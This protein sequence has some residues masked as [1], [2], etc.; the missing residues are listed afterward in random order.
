[1]EGKRGTEGLI[2]IPG[3]D[4]NANTHASKLRR[5]LQPVD[6][7]ILR[8]A[9]A[10]GWSGYGNISPS[11]YFFNGQFSPFNRRFRSQIGLA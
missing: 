8:L 9:L 5:D 2:A 3:S 6:Q 4:S 11:K 10:P 7:V 1:M